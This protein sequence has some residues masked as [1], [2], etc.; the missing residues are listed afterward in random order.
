MHKQILENQYNKCLNILSDAIRNYDE[1]LW[2]DNKN[3]QSPAWQVAYHG[4][5]FTNIYCSATENTIVKWPKQR[6]DYHFLGKKPW[7]PFEEVVVDETY[8]KD[9]LLDFLEFIRKLIPEYLKDMKSE[10][11]CWPAWYEE[12]QLEFHINNLRHLQHHAAEIIE[13]HNNL[14]NINYLWQ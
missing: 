8:T 4:L 11:R 13:R 7:P 10:E 6:E 12:N 1:E 5:Y 3:Y 2:Y 9:E 14:K